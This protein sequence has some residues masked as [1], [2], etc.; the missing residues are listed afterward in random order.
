MQFPDIIDA[1]FRGTFHWIVPQEMQKDFFEFFPKKP[2]ASWEEY[3]HHKYLISIDGYVAATPALAWKLNSQCLVFKQKS[4]YTIWFDQMLIP[5]VHYIPIENDLSDLF[6]KIAWAKDH[7]ELAR[8]IAKEG[9]EFARE[10]IQPE[11]AYLY[12]YKILV[13]YAS[14]QRFKPSL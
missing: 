11:H 14:L 13:H 7:D 4:P 9:G 10:N 6:E 8:H 3:I 1:G 5:W 2:K 12:W